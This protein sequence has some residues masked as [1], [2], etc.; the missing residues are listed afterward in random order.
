M[1]ITSRLAAGRP[2]IQTGSRHTTLACTRPAAARTAAG[3]ASRSEPLARELRAYER[4]ALEL[5]S[6][7]F[8]S[9]GDRAQAQVSTRIGDADDGDVG[10]RGR[11][12]RVGNGAQSP[13]QPRFPR[14]AAAGGGQRPERLMREDV[15]PP[16]KY[17]GRRPK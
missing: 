9:G 6:Y 7:G 4:R 16:A 17:R 15:H 5:G 11:S 14:D 12:C 2:A 3:S 10:P 8:R 1:R 13:V